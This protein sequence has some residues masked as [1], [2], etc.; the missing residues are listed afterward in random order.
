MN[1]SPV[2]TAYSETQGWIGYGKGS[3]WSFGKK[4]SRKIFQAFSC[5]FL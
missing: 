5:S 1:S 3:Q 4:I 2:E